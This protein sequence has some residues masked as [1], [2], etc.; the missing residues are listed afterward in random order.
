[1]LKADDPDEE[2]PIILS[3]RT[4]AKKLN[5]LKQYQQTILPSLTQQNYIRQKIFETLNKDERLDNDQIINIKPRRSMIET[6]S[7]DQLCV[8]SRLPSEVHA[9]LHTPSDG[10]ALHTITYGN[11]IYNYLD[12]IG[13]TA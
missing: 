12:F 1:M 4:K 9:T 6:P 11:K 3:P 13:E 2:N 5:Q 10:K 8:T 7:T